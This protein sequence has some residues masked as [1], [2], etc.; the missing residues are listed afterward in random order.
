MRCVREMG[1]RVLTVHSRIYINFALDGQLPSELHY[2]VPFS[3]K[4][5]LVTS[6]SSVANCIIITLQMKVLVAL[7]ALLMYFLG[8]FILTKCE[9]CACMV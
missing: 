3:P 6:L 4:L 7:Q 2:Y 5:S 9:R 1:M 8:C